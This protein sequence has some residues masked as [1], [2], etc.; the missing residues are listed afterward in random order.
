M[1]DL[2]RPGIEP[3]FPAWAGKFSTARP[4]GKPHTES[5]R[6]V[7]M[8]TCTVVGSVCSHSPTRPVSWLWPCGSPMECYFIVW[9]SF[10]LLYVFFVRHIHA[11]A[12]PACNT[13][14]FQRLRST[15]PYLMWMLFHGWMPL[16]IELSRPVWEQGQPEWAC[17]PLGTGLPHSTL[18][19]FGNA[20]CFWIRVYLHFPNHNQL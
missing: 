2:P 19:R 17:I 5:C 1:W 3:M 18:R 7:I 20:Q 13:F 4:P 10:F 6:Q 16:W 9:I 8:S 15:S 11:W 14:T 12:H